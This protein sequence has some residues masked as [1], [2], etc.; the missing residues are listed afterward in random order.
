MRTSV[1]VVVSRLA[2]SLL[3]PSMILAQQNTTGGGKKGDQGKQ[4]QQPQ[5]E[6][7]ERDFRQSPDQQMNRMRR[8]V[9]L[10]G[11]VVLADGS[12]LP[13]SVNVEL[14]C[15]GSVRQQAFTFSDGNFSFEVGSPSSMAFADA[16]VG[17][18]WSPGGANNPSG[19]RG[20]DSFDGSMNLAGCELRA[21]L[22]GFQSDRLQ[23]GMRRPLDSSEVGN[24]VLRRL[25][26]VSGST[27]SFASLAAPK[28]ARKAFEK[29]TKELRKKKVKYSKVSK[30]LEKAVEIYPKYAAA[31]NLLGA[32]RLKLKDE[33]GASEAFKQAIEADPEYVSPYIELAMLEGDSNHWVEVSRL[34]DRILELNPYIGQAHYFSAVA[35][36]NLGKIDLAAKSIYQ[37]KKDEA[38]KMFADSYYLA[39]A[40]FASKGSATSAAAEFRQLLKS[41]PQDQRADQIREHLNSWE[42]KGLIEKEPPEVSAGDQSELRQE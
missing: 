10:S 18:A 22:P 21:V 34:S 36:F 29:A 16:S 13:G 12:P 17:G 38:S 39:G 5:R 23:L 11:K 28:K 14:R 8:P 20:L 9:R 7:R 27:V 19:Q 3:L 32:T 24:I 25:E 15:S 35:N 41:F 42:A 31:W 4:P 26:K 30:E 6:T 2:L 1:S 33:G 37:Y 40:I